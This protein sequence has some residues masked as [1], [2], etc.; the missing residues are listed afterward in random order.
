MNREGFSFA[1]GKLFLAVILG[2]IVF[3]SGT[4]LYLSEFN[5]FNPITKPFSF[6]F[7]GAI[8]SLE[9]IAFVFIAPLAIAIIAMLCFY[10]EKKEVYYTGFLGVAFGIAVYLAL[11]GADAY[12]IIAGLFVV[13]SVFP[14]VETGYLKKQ[15]FKTL[16]E[17]R[18]VV[19][20]S[21][22]AF[23]TIA[24][25]LFIATSFSVLEN[26]EAMIREFGDSVMELSSNQG[27]DE[28]AQITADLVVSA[29]LETVRAITSDTAFEMLLQKEDAE[30]AGFVESVQSLENYLYT[31]EAREEVLERIEDNQQERI[32]DFDYMRNQSPMIDLAAKNYW[33]LLGFSTAFSFLMFANFFM[34]LLSGAYALALKKIID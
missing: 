18:T 34:A 8:F 24:L 12:R 25:G 29:Q 19:A 14:L 10:R 7:L 5:G 33:L 22:S 11:A 16:T 13:L 6:D 2:F 17:F 30:V 23:L 28:I 32:I 3:L 20:G 9:F 31:P 15:E 4:L 26:E 21:R 27:H 1:G